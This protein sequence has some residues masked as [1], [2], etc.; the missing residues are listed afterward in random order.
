MTTRV[1]IVG[2]TG[3]MGRL[4]G[5][6]VENT[7]GYDV[8][9]RLDSTSALSEML[10]ADVA[11]DLTVP[12]VSQGVVDFAIDNGIRVLVG[13]SGW[14]QPRIDALGHKL[15]GRT[16]VGAVIIPNFSLG[17]VLGTAFAALAARFFDSIEIVEAHQA[18]KVDSP[19]GTAVRTAELMAAARAGL[20]PV[21]APHVDQRARGQQV[22][23]VPVHS[24]R[25]AGVLARQD[26]IFGGSGETL[27]I[28]HNTLSA[29]AYERGILVALAAARDCVGVTV[30][31]DQLIDLGLTDAVLEPAAASAGSPDE[32]PAGPPPGPEDAEMEP[33]E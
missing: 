6:L 13:T 19:S 27:T 9:A 31:L 24:L 14:S 12:A 26:V 22:A 3:K 18:G 20:G 25:L 17:S 10:G 33:G 28:T 7:P 4:V 8:V 21:S 16:D 29:E 30:G 1:A 32:P 15:K 5:G 23:T 2:A 11:I